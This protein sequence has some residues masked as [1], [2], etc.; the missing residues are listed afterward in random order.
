MHQSIKLQSAM[1]LFKKLN[2]GF[3][4]HKLII[5]F[6]HLTGPLFP[7]R[8]A[9]KLQVKKYSMILKFCNYFK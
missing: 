8:I 7:M 3:T 6:T 1:Q 9:K 2:G 5:C 4:L